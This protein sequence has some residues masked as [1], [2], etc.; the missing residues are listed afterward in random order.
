MGHATQGVA[1]GWN[2]VAPLALEIGFATHLKHTLCER[3]CFISVELQAGCADDSEFSFPCV[4]W[5]ARDA[6]RPGAHSTQSVERVQQPQTGAVSESAP[7]YVEMPRQTLCVACMAARL[8]LSKSKKSGPEARAPGRKGVG[9]RQ[10]G[11]NSLVMDRF[12]LLPSLLLRAT[13]GLL[14][15][16]PLLVWAGLVLGGEAVR[17]SPYIVRGVRVA[18]IEVGNLTQR[19]ATEQLHLAWRTQPLVLESADRTPLA[20]LPP[21]TLGFRLESGEAVAQAYNIGRDTETPWYA[22]WRLLTVSADIP[23]RITPA[24]EAAESQLRLLAP[25][26]ALDPQDA[27]LVV[28]DGRV[29]A[30][31]AVPGRQLDLAATLARWQA[32]YHDGL[33]TGR[34]PVVLQELSPTLA[35]AGSYEA[36]A[37]RFLAHPPALEAYDPIRNEAWPLP[38]PA[39]QWQRW[40]AFDIV[41]GQLAPT[42]DGAAIGRF[43]AEAG[44]DLDG[45]VFSAETAAATA[46][47][48]AAGEAEIVLRL[49]HLPGTYTVQPGDTLSAI[50]RAH[51]IPYP[52]IEAANPGIG[53][54]RPGQQLTLPSPDDLVPLP[55]VRHKRI[56]VSITRQRMWAYENGALKWEWPVSTGIAESPTAPGVFQIQSHERQA[57]ANSWDLHMPWF[58]GIYL[59][60]PNINFMNGFHGFPTRD[61]VNLLWTNSLG[62][63]ATYGCILVDN[64]NAELL[65]D[66]AE[67]GVIVEVQP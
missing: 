35:D 29:V 3:V 22:P 2:Q 30:L 21:G 57:Y 41:G 7:V 34:L 51:G 1:L 14:L 23:P 55:V 5:R 15:L 38:L 46:R 43:L 61:R 67:K 42:V 40:L 26:V 4:A 27:R 18:G 64:R 16:T 52:W 53:T 6:E 9:R 45:R 56:I 44:R 62:R 48:I 49:S 32:A 60:A 19:A 65:Y 36:A 13:A 24:W 37:N 31:P 20:T 11:Y 10:S 39:A 17:R 25:S 28:Q 33:A 59:P 12:R 66:W 58:M 47:A 54:L 63:P 8:L 50:G